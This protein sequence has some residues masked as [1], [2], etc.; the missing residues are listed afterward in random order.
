MSILRCDLPPDE[1]LVWKDP[2]QSPVFG[3]QL[4]VSQTQ[5]AIILGSGELISVLQPGAH[6]LKT[7]NIPVLKNFIQDGDDSFPFDIW[8]PPTLAPSNFFVSGLSNGFI[9][10]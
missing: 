2:D 8:Y 7:A 6:T 1:Y 10:I 4:I 5:E 3:S 9:I